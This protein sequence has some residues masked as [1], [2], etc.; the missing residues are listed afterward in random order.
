MSTMLP[1][2]FEADVLNR[3]AHTEEIEIEVPHLGADAGF[4][5]TTLWVV[6]VGDAVYIRS[7][8]GDA[9]HWYQVV[10]EHPQAA[11]YLDGHRTPVRAVPVTDA[12]TIAQVSDAY[13]RKYGDDPALPSMVREEILPTTLRLD[14]R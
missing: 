5:L 13:H 9:G 10:R 1:R 2:H 8:S 3:L 6:V 4:H 7:W 14:S 11:V 12:A